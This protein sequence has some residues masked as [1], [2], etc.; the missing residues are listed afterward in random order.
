MART[1]LG[2]AAGLATIVIIVAA[3]SDDGSDTGSSQPS[4]VSTE[5]TTQMPTT[6]TTTAGAGTTTS[7]DQGSGGPGV[8]RVDQLDTSLSDGNGAAGSTYFT[9]VFTNRSSHTCVLDGFPGVS[10]VSGPDSDP[11]GSPA[12]R[13]GDTFGPVSLHP[14]D[15]A[16]AQLR[17][18]NVE[19]YPAARCTPMRAS[20]L[21][22]Y[23]PNSRESV[24]LAHSTTACAS[25]SPDVHQLGVQAVE[26]H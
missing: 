18:A 25:T 5:S 15:T 10:Y 7:P 3:C 26:R 21:R 16:S 14:G 2:Y 1:H 6:S 19:N 12:Q 13:D 11:I 23:P 22:V 24:Y 17:A 4:A 9:I 8:C 20:G